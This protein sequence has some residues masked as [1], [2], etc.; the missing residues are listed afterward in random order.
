[1]MHNN[2]TND[3]LEILFNLNNMKNKKSV[4]FFYSNRIT[5]NAEP[6]TAFVS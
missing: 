4:A 2:R 1:M 5:Y 3:S 6:K